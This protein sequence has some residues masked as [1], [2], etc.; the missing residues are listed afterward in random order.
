MKKIIV[1]IFNFFGIDVS[2]RSKN[3]NTLFEIDGFSYCQSAP[4]ANLAPW[5]GDVKFKEI[6]DIVKN[7]NT[8]V[9]IYR[10]YELW[11]LTEKAFELNS[12]AGILEVGVWRGG[13]SAIMA[14]KLKNINA[15][16]PLYMADTFTG[17]V[18]AGKEDNYYLGGEHAD[19][20]DQ[21]VTAL[22]KNVVGYSNFA[23]LKG[24]FPDDTQHFVPAGLQFSLCHIDVDVYTSAMDI[25]NWI[26][27][28]MVYGGMIVFDD[29]GFHTCTGV[30]KYV[31]ASRHK[32][33]RIII[34]NLNG[35]AIVI[36]LK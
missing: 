5:I 21:Q 26:W 9:D 29:Y 25:E 19:T 1:S 7:N 23:I 10:C 16:A 11:Q 8:L 22:M 36:K 31:E 15:A 6:Y 27:D 28:R 18:K 20:S 35:H 17:V 4:T 13:T 24:I 30:A 14:Q 32:T 12:S 34:H 2:L 3:K 33:D